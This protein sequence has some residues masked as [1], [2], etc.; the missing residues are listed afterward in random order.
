MRPLGKQ[1][2]H[3]FQPV[4]R[5]N[6]IGIQTH[7]DLVAGCFKTA[8]T[9]RRE[10]LLLLPND[11]YRVLFGDFNRSI[12]GVV[13]NQD[14]LFGRLGLP[15]Y[16]FK[17]LSDMGLLIVGRNNYTDA[18]TFERR[19]HDTHNNGFTTKGASGPP[20]SAFAILNAREKPLFQVEGRP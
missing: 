14:D 1:I 12:G 5:H 18:R 4:P 11:P 20:S 15:H 19:W 9:G 17:T 3:R 16:A 2:T 6:R 10:T 7:D 13:V 8:V